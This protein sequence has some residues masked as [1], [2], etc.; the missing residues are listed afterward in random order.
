[1]SSETYNLNTESV[2][3]TTITS[4]DS[5]NPTRPTT[6]KTTINSD[7]KPYQSNILAYQ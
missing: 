7:T 6:T 2:D 1:M 5:T 4:K 3:P